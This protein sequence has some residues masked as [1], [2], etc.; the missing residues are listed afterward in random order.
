MEMRSKMEMHANIE[1]EK[2][3]FTAAWTWNI[4]WKQRKTGNNDRDENG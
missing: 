1:Q 3:T 2:D 4:N